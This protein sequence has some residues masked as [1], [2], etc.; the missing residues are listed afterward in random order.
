MSKNK[1]FVGEWVDDTPKCGV[2]S[3]VHD[4]EKPEEKKPETYTDPEPQSLIPNIE[5]AHPSELLQDSLQIVKKDRLFYRARYMPLVELYTKSEMPELIH[6]FSLA[7]GS[8]DIDVCP[9][10]DIMTTLSRMKMPCSEDTIK[11]YLKTLFK[12]EEINLQEIDFEMFARLVA[13]ILE[14]RADA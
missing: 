12:D 5:L 6:E 8:T 1:V 14:T 9:L 7:T 2:Y 3:E 10:I 4:P 13:I 11:D